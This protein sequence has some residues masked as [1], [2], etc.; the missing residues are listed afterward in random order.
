[1]C[2]RTSA[3]GSDSYVL[4]ADLI[5]LLEAAVIA[6]PPAERIDFARIQCLEA[7]RKAKAARVDSAE[8]LVAFLSDDD[9]KDEQTEADL[10][11]LDKDALIKL[12]RAE[13][14]INGEDLAA[15]EAREKK[16]QTGSQALD[17]LVDS[18][19]RARRAELLQAMPAKELLKLWRAQQSG[20]DG[21]ILQQL[22]VDAVTREAT[23]AAK[24]YKLEL[25]RN[26]NDEW[27][28]R[29][30]L[31]VVDALLLQQALQYLEQQTELREFWLF[32][33]AVRAQGD[34]TDKLI[35]PTLYCYMVS[36]LFVPQ[37]S[38]QQIAQF[39]ALIQHDGDLRDK[40][41]FE[42]LLKQRVDRKLTSPDN[43]II[44]P[45]PVPPVPIPPPPPPPIVVRIELPEV[46]LPVFED[47]LAA[48]R[49][50]QD[51]GAA[52]VVTRS[53]EIPAGRVGSVR[54]LRIVSKNKAIAQ[55][56][57]LAVVRSTVD[58]QGKVP[59]DRW[60]VRAAVIPAAL[61]G[62][63]RKSLCDELTR[64][65]TEQMRKYNWRKLTLQ[66]VFDANSLVTTPDQLRSL[67]SPPFNHS[68]D[69]KVTF[70]QN[71][72]NNV[73]QADAHGRSLTN[74]VAL[75]RLAMEGKN[76]C[77]RCNQSVS[78][79]SSD[80]EFV[81]DGDKILHSACAAPK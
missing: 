74:R 13:K 8:D 25:R 67:C 6:K 1:M 41:F 7:E 77:Q 69:G 71:L 70:V 59:Q 11:A 45:V 62:A 40:A 68:A 26:A 21:A 35:I 57:V 64:I 58:V 39:A 12:E 49:A 51:N 17:R 44:P 61:L 28:V 2:E 72:V 9:E 24:D 38:E 19:I 76:V 4:V 55:S 78:K 75:R 20:K 65:S 81:I 47:G 48:C 15:L 80:A 3:D 32:R 56:G 33:Q 16:L 79:Q 73:V 31:P 50:Q 14:E 29:N 10:N 52:M 60:E 36:L 54:A 27:F 22:I 63:T 34:D 23:T 66:V 37:T 46:E 30:A 5:N 42:P 43:G 53:F 18:F